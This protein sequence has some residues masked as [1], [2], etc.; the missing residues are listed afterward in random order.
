MENK[1][2][3][4]V[5][6]HTLSKS[7]SGKDNDMVYIGI[8][9]KKNVKQR[10]LNGRGYDSNIHFSRA[11][12]KYGW[13]NFSHEVLFTGLSKEEAERKEIELISYYDSTNPLKGYNRDLGGN[14]VGKHSESTKQII[15]QKNKGRVRSEEF[16]QRLSEAH[17]GKPKSEEFRKNLS[18]AKSIPVLCIETGITYDSSYAASKELG[19]DNS[20]ISKC[21]KGINKM[22]GGFHWMYADEYSEEK[23]NEILEKSKNNQHK[24]VLCVEVNKIFSTIMEASKI[25]GV[26]CSN[27]SM[28][29]SGKIKTAGQLEN[30]Q[31]LHWKYI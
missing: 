20:T 29:C 31:R 22:A 17:S 18:K 5:Y 19:I 23:A 10:W 25:M 11:I 16:R 14:S 28:C 21:C 26:T 15:S 1:R 3:Y 13:D 12:Q 24:Q 8:T 30:G 6:K 2:N 4:C 7:F 27:I 9:C